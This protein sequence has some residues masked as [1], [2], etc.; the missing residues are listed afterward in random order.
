MI[1]PTHEQLAR[2]GVLAYLTEEKRQEV[3]QMPHGQA[4][5][6]VANL[7]KRVKELKK[8]GKL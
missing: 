6:H 5:V 3:L 7:E 2:W 4:R 1:T 8:K